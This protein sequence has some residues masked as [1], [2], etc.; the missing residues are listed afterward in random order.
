MDWAKALVSAGVRNFLL[1]GCLVFVCLP[2]APGDALLLPGASRSLLLDAER[3]GDR[4]LVAGER[5]HILFSDDQGVSW[6]Q[7]QVPTRQM[8]TA[9]SFPSPLRGWAVGHDGLILASVDGGV[10]WVLQRDGLAEQVSLN[11]E[12]LRVAQRRLEHAR[13]NL[14]AATGAGE[15]E[16]L[17]E[18]LAE[19][20][21]DVK[22]A[23]DVLEEAVHAPPLL[24][25]FFL[26][27]LRGF[28]VG[29]FNTLLRTTDGGVSW[30]LESGR[31][32]NPDEYHLNAIT[33]NRD[34][35]VWIAAEGGLLFHS[36]DAGETWR[37][38]PSPYHGS[39]F[40]IIHHG[41]IDTLL[42]FGLRGN[43]YRSGDSGESWQRVP[44][45]T[46]R[47]LAGGQFVN[48][49]YVLLVGGVGTLLVSA[50]GGQNFR[51]QP[52]PARPNFSAVTSSGEGAVVVG[53]GGVRRV[54]PYGSGQ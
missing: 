1:P 23:E 29:A 51:Q 38:L 26:D 13:Q 18:A 36:A 20:E 31:L 28:A 12:R 46:S 45:E 27:E 3:A 14:L 16:N 8:L 50:D 22:D 5:G 44:V 40:G 17:L 39:W 54:F 10:H 4:L 35:R 7:A 48:A 42:V 15:R 11:R 49:R 47:T 6:S 30:L 53:Q 43:L 41:E 25:V 33:G 32:E 2:A 19:R 9:I 34:G 24:D 21:L 52:L 37:S